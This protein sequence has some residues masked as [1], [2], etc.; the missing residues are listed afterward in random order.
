LLYLAPMKKIF[1]YGPVLIVIAAV[2]WG[3]D[4]VLRRSLFSLPPI[5]IVFYE[6]LIGLIL[7]LP[8]LVLAAKKETLSKSEWSAVLW[9]SLLSGMLGTLWFT[10]A[11]LKVQFIPFSVV[12]LL[13]KLQPIFATLAGVVL[14]KEKITKEHLLWA[15]FA[16]VAAYFV[17]FPGGQVN[18]ATG[19]GTGIAALFAV[20][21]AFAWGSSTA[22]S[23]FAL[24]NHSDT[25]ITGLRFFFTTLMS[26]AGVYVLGQSASLVLPSLPQFGTLVTIA[27]ST[28]MLALW[29]YYKGLKKTRVGV[30][31]ILELVFPL[32][33]VLIDLFL[34]K[35]TLATSQY[36]AAGA[37]LYSIWQMSRLN[38]VKA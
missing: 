15:G 32:T 18:F 26:L 13:Q 27:L 3:L 2:L 4:G 38:Q 22:V 35:T 10:T 17:T 36:L 30:A 11:L 24:K 8:A 12:F 6:H 34:Y 37:L 14:L 29:I 25:L 28:G 1:S 31:T 21:A 5:T 16:L 33:A 20:G 7:M 23:R 9:V 19:T